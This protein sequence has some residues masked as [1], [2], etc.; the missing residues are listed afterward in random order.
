MNCCP[1]N[2]LSGSCPPP[3]L[4]HFPCVN[5]YTCIQVHIKSVRVGVRYRVLGLRHL[6]QSPVNL[7]VTF[8][9]DDILLCLPWVLSFYD[10]TLTLSSAVSLLVYV[11]LFLRQ[12][13]SI[14]EKLWFKI[15]ML[16]HSNLQQKGVTQVY[17]ISAISWH[18]KR[19]R[20]PL[21]RRMFAKYHKKL[22]ISVGVVEKEEMLC[23]K[24]KC[25]FYL[26]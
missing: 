3:H 7:Q 19:H 22:A 20:N 5:K 14:V 16:L 15:Y 10:V 11:M 23:Q 25:Y 2:I 18:T 12:N 8:L 26:N 4:A 1:S 17:S 21:E 24:C 6:P 13:T 9:D